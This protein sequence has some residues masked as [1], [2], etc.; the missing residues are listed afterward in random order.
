[1]QQRERERKERLATIRA[2]VDEGWT[3]REIAAGL[4]ISMSA[5]EKMRRQESRRGK[6]P[7]PADAIQ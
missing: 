1:M 7:Q 3:T 2:H 5:A 4:A 6:Q